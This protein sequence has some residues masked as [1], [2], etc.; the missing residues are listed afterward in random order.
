MTS[1]AFPL[2]PTCG[3][4]MKPGPSLRE[5]RLA[6]LREAIAR[7]ERKQSDRPGD[8]LSLGVP[9]I[10]DHLPRGGLGAGVLHEVMA[11]AYSDRPSAFGF[12]CALM[13]SALR[14]RP[15]PAMLVMTTRALSDRGRPYARGLGQL[16]IDLQRLVLIEA[17]NDKDAHW[18]LEET[19]RSQA[20]PAIVL[21]A[22]SGA[23]DLTVSRRLN[24]AAAAH[25][26]PLVVVR[27]SNAAGTTAAATRWRVSSTS[28]TADRF[29]ALGKNTWHARLE[30]C[31]NGRAGEWLIEWTDVSH[32]FR[33]AQSLADHTPASGAAI[34]F[35]S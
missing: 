12:A 7:I 35:A 34:R 21:G 9:Q 18:A 22:V 16:G 19:L 26:T 28:G 24:L 32:C 2:N 3:N 27:S 11:A 6:S 15:G 30:R 20:R 4:P 5:A 8:L 14:A 25:G 31:R 29:G 17:R 1:F 13:A 23:L 10:Q 33:L